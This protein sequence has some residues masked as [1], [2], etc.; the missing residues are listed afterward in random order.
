MLFRFGKIDLL[1]YSFSKMVNETPLH[2]LFF[3]LHKNE[4]SLGPIKRFISN[5]TL[6]IPSLTP[7]STILDHIDL[8]DDYLLINHLILIYK[9][10]IY[11]SRIRS[12]TLIV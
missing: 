7:Q 10:Y 2:P 11:N 5:T 6:F 12:L 3:G 9:S 1:L 8:L 4:T